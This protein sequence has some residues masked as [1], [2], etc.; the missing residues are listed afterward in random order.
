MIFI[1]NER[2]SLPP[3]LPFR[4]SETWSKNSHRDRFDGEEVDGSLS[5]FV[6][7]N[8]FSFVSLSLSTNQVATCKQE[9]DSDS[10]SD[11]DS[12]TR[13]LTS[14]PFFRPIDSK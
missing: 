13:V 5:A 6:N 10:D 1:E 11:S 7:S 12:D 9:C 3:P 4:R 14:F 2:H 8:R